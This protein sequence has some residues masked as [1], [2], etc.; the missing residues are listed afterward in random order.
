MKRNYETIK[1]SDFLAYCN[2]FD[3]QK[4]AADSLGTTAQ[5][6]YAM[7]KRASKGPEMRVLPGMA[8]TLALSHD[9]PQNKKGGFT[10]RKAV[11][12][13]AP[14]IFGT[15]K[16]PKAVKTKAEKSTTSDK[17]KMDV[18]NVYLPEEPMKTAKQAKD[19]ISSAMN[20]P[21]LILGMRDALMEQNTQDVAT[22]IMTD[23]ISAKRRGCSTDYVIE[24]VER[25]VKSFKTLYNI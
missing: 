24:Q 5:H 20:V 22:S 16:K 15:K 21:Q 1:S 19:Q 3:K 10:K 13:V 7:K 23:L 4:D 12:E 9:R 11:S 2:R 25:A 8:N 17:T 6:L 18:V 14:I